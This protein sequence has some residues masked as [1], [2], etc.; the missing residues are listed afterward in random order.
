MKEKNK[1]FRSWMTSK[2]NLHRDAA[3]LNYTKLRNKA[4]TLLRKSERLF[5]KVIAQRSK[6]NPKPFWSH[7][8]RKLKTKC[9]VAPLLED[10]KNKSSL[11]FKDKEKANIL[12]KQFSSVFTKEPE[13]ATPII[14]K[15]TNSVLQDISITV[16]MVRLHLLKLNVNKSCDP[17][18]IYPRMLLELADI[19]AG[20]VAFLLNM[21]LA[22]GTMPKDWELLKLERTQIVMVNGVES[23]PTSVLSGI[24]QG[25]VLGPL[26]FVVYINDI[27]DNVESH[28]LLFADDTK[29]YRVI[30][31]KEDTKSLQDDL[32]ELEKWSDKWLL[33]FHPDKCH[34]LN[35]G[36]FDN[37]KHTERYNIWNHELEH[38]FEEKD[39]GIIVDPN[40]H[41]RNIYLQ[42]LKR[43]IQ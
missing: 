3:R 10:V 4:K 15:R 14:D 32:H 42:K 26:L 43:P 27:L 11:R 24:P 36:K 22:S 39:L 13:G 29:I 23:E 28:G 33:K 7:T 40:L 17:D 21:I 41:L 25:T 35:L 8:R 6:S 18:E 12:Q 31:K 30:T 9:S 37:I 34:V 38:V 19:I 5:E 2:S 1:A 16:D 20:P